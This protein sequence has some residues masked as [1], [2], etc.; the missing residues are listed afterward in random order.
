MGVGLAGYGSSSKD[1]AVEDKAAKIG[2]GGESLVSLLDG[3]HVLPGSHLFDTFQCSECPCMAIAFGALSHALP[4]P[5]SGK[6]VG[7]VRRFL[8]RLLGLPLADQNLLFGY[9]M[10]TLNAEIRC[11]FHNQPFKT[12]DAI[13]MML[14]HIC[15]CMSHW[16]LIVKS[17]YDLFASHPPPQDG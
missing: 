1:T 12:E 7:D 16:F 11:I 15:T 6:D 8:N 14:L 17:N 13:L 2:E 9:F 4:D 10:A 3:L 5:P